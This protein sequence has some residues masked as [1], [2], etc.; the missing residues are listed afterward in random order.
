MNIIMQNA[1]YL[2]FCG[3]CMYLACSHIKERKTLIHRGECDCS[4]C[5]DTLPN[6]WP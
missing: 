6:F 5:W 3:R 1:L 4:A 2:L